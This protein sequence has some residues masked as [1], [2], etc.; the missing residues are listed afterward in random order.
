MSIGVELFLPLVFSPPPSRLCLDTSP[1]SGRQEFKHTFYRQGAAS[2]ECVP[3][4]RKLPLPAISWPPLTRGLA[5]PQVLTEGE[6]KANG[7][8]N[9]LSMLKLLLI[10]PTSNVCGFPAVC[11]ISPSV[12]ALPR[13]LPR[14]WEAR[15]CGYRRHS[16]YSHPHLKSN[17]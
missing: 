17:V 2:D 5:K 3:S 6:K 10:F 7:K 13:H 14:Q 8:K 16:N 4:A 11:G 1:V 15:V 9:S 12:E